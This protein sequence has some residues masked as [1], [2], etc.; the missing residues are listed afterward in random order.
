MADAFTLLFVFFLFAM[1][2]TKVWLAW[3]QI[4]HVAAHAAA[5]PAQKDAP[6]GE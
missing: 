6:K 3:R 2:A 1:V 4:R 5:V